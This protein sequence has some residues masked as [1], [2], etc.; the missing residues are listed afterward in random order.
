MSDHFISRISD[1]YAKFAGKF[2][3]AKPEVFVDFANLVKYVRPTAPRITNV[4]CGWQSYSEWRVKTCPKN[5]LEIEWAVICAICVMAKNEYNEY[6]H[7]RFLA[8][9]IFGQSAY[10][11]LKYMNID[12]ITINRFLESRIK[13]INQCVKLYSEKIG[14]ANVAHAFDCFDHIIHLELCDFS[15][16]SEYQK[17]LSTK[18]PEDVIAKM[19]MPGFSMVKFTDKFGKWFAKTYNGADINAHLRKYFAATC[20]IPAVRDHKFIEQKISTAQV[21]ETLHGRAA[22]VDWSTIET[23]YGD[24]YDLPYLHNLMDKLLISLFQTQ[25]KCK[26][27]NQRMYYR[28]KCTTRIK[29]II[30]HQVYEKNAMYNCESFAEYMPHD[31]LRMCA[32]YVAPRT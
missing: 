9:A 12:L 23:I 7:A 15:P 29:D 8:R 4:T 26:Y 5:A 13:Q 20:I 6:P 21:I 27:T 31:L 16:N 14:I 11:M 32:D 18:Q 30:V 3:A 28:C 10:N 19:I 1:A 25:W 2:S 22:Y 17:F 24:K